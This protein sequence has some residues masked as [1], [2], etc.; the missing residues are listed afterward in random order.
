M[1]WL[2][3]EHDLGDRERELHLPEKL[4]AGAAH[5]GRGFD[6]LGRHAAQPVLGVA[7]GGHDGVHD[8]REVGGELPDLE[9]H[10][11]RDEEHEERHGL[12]RVVDRADEGGEP[13]A[14]GRPHPDEPTDHE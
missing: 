2:S 1:V 8:D 12:E 13:V 5:G 7:D 3:P 10:Q 9:E 6:D 14:V 11:H 4:V